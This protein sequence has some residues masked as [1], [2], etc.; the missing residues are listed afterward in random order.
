M[1]LD[2]RLASLRLAAPRLEVRPVDEA[3]RERPDR[4]RLSFNGT[5]SVKFAYLDAPERRG[6]P[7]RL[8][9]AD[10][11]EQ[12]RVFYGSP[13]HVR[14]TLALRQRGWELEPKFHFGYRERGLC[15][16]RSSLSVD[17]YAAYWT[18]RIDQTGAIGRGDWERELE[19]LIAD[20]V[21]D[22]ADRAQFDA[23]FTGT[24]RTYASP[25]PA[26]ELAHFWSLEEAGRPEFPEQ[27]RSVLAQALNALGEEEMLT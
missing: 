18:R 4:A 13:A 1:T 21:F 12:A 23:D 2:D 22:P 6:V 26:V 9:P 20:G 10:T 25:R 11:L 27:L 8:Y 14:Q 24:R 3:L 19:Q 17:E 5:T 16:S 7:L 15:W